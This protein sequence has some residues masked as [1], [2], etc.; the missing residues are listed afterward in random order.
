MLETEAIFIQLTE[1]R[2]VALEDSPPRPMG[3]VGTSSESWSRSVS[4]MAEYLCDLEGT[5]GI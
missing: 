5:F 2:A 3:D 1:H 4:G